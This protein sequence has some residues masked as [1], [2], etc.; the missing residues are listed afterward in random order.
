MSRYPDLIAIPFNSVFIRD[1]FVPGIPDSPLTPP[2]SG[3]WVIISG[4]NLILSAGESGLTLPMGK[5]PDWL[6]ASNVPL[7]IGSW[8]GRPL[9]I[10]QAA[11][12]ITI[13]PPFVMEA[14]NAAVQTID[15]STLGI[16]GLAR[17]ILNWEQQSRFCSLCGGRTGP[18]VREWGRFC[19]VCNSKQFPK[20]SP[21][22][23][24]L[25]KRDDEL[26]LVRDAAWPAGRYSLAAGYAGFGE[27]LE[28]CAVREVKEETGID[29][30][31]VTYV[32]SQSW[33]FPSQL[34]AGF[35][36]TYAS[37]ELVVDHS[38]LEDARWFPVSALP[39]LPPTRSIA[40]R[41]ID[42]YCR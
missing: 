12:N 18:F 42:T 33:P 6:I 39:A 5:I 20:I 41:I 14:L 25:V 7:T 24:V 16:G 17:Q 34:M 21:C 19:S 38:E 40:R 8:R 27:S 23:I 35:V 31:D 9:H 36:A 37:G 1:L 15:D 30:A 26:L 2:A 13:R 29:I 10:I 11:S 28:D 3:Y 32:G 4:N 22:A